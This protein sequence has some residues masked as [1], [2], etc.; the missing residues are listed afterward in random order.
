MAAKSATS[1]T[2][3]D[4]TMKAFVTFRVT[5]DKL[6]PDEVTQLLK[7]QPTHIRVKGTPYS[8]GRSDN[9]V[10]STNIWFFSTDS[11]IVSHNIFDH[12]RLALFVLGFIG[13][14]VIEQ[15]DTTANG[16]FIQFPRLLSLKSLLEKVTAKATM[17]FFWHGGAAS[18]DPKVPEELFDLLRLAQIDVEVDF[19][20]D[21]DLTRSGRRSNR[22]L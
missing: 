3:S 19:D 16:R 2:K 12:I 15:L 14:S 5:G 21:E 17:T 7:V 4:Q 20:K 13:P 10:P 22:S 9:I 6:A 11:V 1:L 18:I 8:T